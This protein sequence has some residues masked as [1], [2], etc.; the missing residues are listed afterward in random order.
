MKSLIR[1]ARD[2]GLLDLIHSKVNQRK[3]DAR[4]GEPYFKKIA[5]LKDSE[6]TYVCFLPWRVSMQ[7]AIN[8]GLVPTRHSHVT[9]EIPVGIANPDPRKSREHI[10]QLVQ[11]FE[12]QRLSLSLKYSSF[13][14][15]HRCNPS[16]ANCK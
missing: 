13:R 11:D 5:D 12:E 4:I 16:D 2:Y 1:I 7:R 10:L 3:K 6:E 8:F 9:Y 14:L 15:Q